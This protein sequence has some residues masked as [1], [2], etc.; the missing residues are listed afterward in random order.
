MTRPTR[1]MAYGVA[2][3][4]GRE[5]ARG[6]DGSRGAAPSTGVARTHVQSHGGESFRASARRRRRGWSNSCAS[7]GRPAQRQR[8]VEYLVV[9]D[10]LGVLPH[11]LDKPRHGVSLDP[12][13]S[14][15]GWS[16]HGAGARNIKL[17]GCRITHTAS[18]RSSGGNDSTH[19]TVTDCVVADL[20]AG[21]VKI[22]VTGSCGPGCACAS[23]ITVSNIIAHG[24]RIHPRSACGSANSRATGSCT[25]R[26]TTSTTRAF[27]GGWTWGYAQLAHDNLVADNR[28][29]P[30]AKGVLSDMG[31][32]YTL[33]V[34]RCPPCH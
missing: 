14:K 28:M 4:R 23:D 5:C 25:T 2:E 32:I 12:G 10:S 19:N 11:K 22:G 18:G 16:D 8:F 24:G 27:P 30:S 13:R 1:S 31:G 7:A 29:T 21:G 26:S 6:P 20:G 17:D 34:C 33:G 15:S 3:R 9:R